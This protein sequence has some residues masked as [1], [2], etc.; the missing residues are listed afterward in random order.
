MTPGT[1]HVSSVTLFQC[2]SKY[3]KVSLGYILIPVTVDD[4]GW[5]AGLVQE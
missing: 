3:T 5:V 1:P 4:D 2:T